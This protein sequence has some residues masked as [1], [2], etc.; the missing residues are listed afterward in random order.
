MLEAIGIYMS[1]HSETRPRPDGQK[2]LGI[3]TGANPSYWDGGNSP[4]Q[5]TVQS[6]THL[7]I[8]RS[9]QD[10]RSAETPGYVRRWEPE[11]RLLFTSRNATIFQDL[12]VCRLHL[13][14]VGFIS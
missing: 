12:I 6:E 13:A 14:F 9:H 11:D 10:P 1:L 4:M 2:L 8:P 7:D 5:S 3:A